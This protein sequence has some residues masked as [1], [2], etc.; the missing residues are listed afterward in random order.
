MITAKQIAVMMIDLS[1]MY[2]EGKVIGMKSYF[3]GLFL[4][5]SGLF[6][7]LK[8]LFNWNIPTFRVLIGLFLLSLGLSIIFGGSFRDNSNIIFNEARL[9]YETGRKDYNIVFGQGIIDFGNAK[10]E[11]LG[12]KVEVS[13]VFGSSE[14]ILPKSLTVE[15]KANSVFS[16]TGFP[17]NTNLSFGDRKFLSDPQGKGQPDMILEVNT[18]F[19]NTIIRH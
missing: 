2:N 8:H 4:I 14:I 1:N 10:A 18:V 5:L 7:V 13:T 3:W 11:D 17:D 16:S 6:L 19:G 15:I 9:E 12:K